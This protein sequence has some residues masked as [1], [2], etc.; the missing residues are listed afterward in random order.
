MD[1]LQLLS[2]P[3][4]SLAPVQLAFDEKDGSKMPYTNDLNGF[5]RQ[6]AVTLTPR[7]MESVNAY[8]SS[9]EAVG[10]VNCLSTS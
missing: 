5:K 4:G 6:D 1:L 2:F 8:L 7:A 10:E 3:G 9:G